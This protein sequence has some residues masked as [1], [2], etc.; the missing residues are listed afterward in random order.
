M[1]LRFYDPKQGTISLDGKSYPSMK[2]NQLR[3][4][5]GVVTQETE[6]FALVCPIYLQYPLFVI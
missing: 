2:V 5:F 6:L 3:K 1:L 4:L